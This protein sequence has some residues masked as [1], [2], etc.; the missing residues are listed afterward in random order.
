[1]RLKGISWIE[2]NFEKVFAGAFGVAA[3]GV[4]VWQFAG[5]A[6]SVTVGKKTVPIEQAFSEVVA[7]ARRAKGEIELEQPVPVLEP[8]ANPVAKF[9]QQFRGP[10]APRPEL[11]V[12]LGDPTPLPT[13]SSNPG[14]QKLAGLSELQ[15]PAPTL[16]IVQPYMITVHPDEVARDKSVA[17]VLPN[18]MPYDKASVT[19]QVS[20][21]GKALR[22]ILDT[23]PDGTGP[24]R[25]MNRLWWEGMQILGTELHRQEL[26]ADGS[27]G[28]EE[29]V[30][31]MP[32]RFTQMNEI[33]AGVSSMEKLSLLKEKAR[34][35]SVEVRR[36]TYYR[37][38]IGEKW[39]P[40]IEQRAADE[41]ARAAGPDAESRMRRA[42]SEL[43]KKIDSLNDTLSKLPPLTQPTDRND[44]PD[45]RAPSG[46]G[47]GGGSGGGGG[48][49]GASGGGGGGGGGNRPPA[50]GQPSK[51]NDQ[52]R[53]T[54]ERNR[55][56]SMK[57]ADDFRRKLGMAPLNPQP[58]D[59]S[60]PTTMPATSDA[61]KFAPTL[62]TESLQL[63]AHDVTVERG[64]SYRY[65]M[66]LVFDNPMFGKGSVMLPE[67]AE[68]A[69]ATTLR[70]EPSE[71]SDPVAT[72]KETYYFVTSAAEAGGALN[73]NRPADA[74]ADLF[75]F[76]LGYWRRGSDTFEPGDR[77]QAEVSY[78]DFSKLDIKPIDGQPGMAN[79]PDAPP[80]GGRD[81]GGGGGGGGGKGR[82]GGFA[83]PPVDNPDAAMSSSGP[84]PMLSK[85]ITA[86]AVLL[87]IER[88]ALERRNGARSAAVTET[89][90]RRADGSIEVRV[91]DNDKADETYDR[92]N[93]SSE[94]AR[95][96]TMPKKSELDPNNQGD[97]RD[98][99]PIAP[100]APGSDGGGGSG[101]GSGG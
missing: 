70:S 13:G 29:K 76:T 28:K 64:K 99:A 57:Q 68:W 24:L 61:N 49:R 89:Y 50:V 53:K 4:L 73:P 17:E 23:D 74:R 2:Q 78:P 3:L 16:P 5:P 35:R 45:D 72:D 59:A 56:E 14:D 77:L 38:L 51:E 62:D 75:I 15:I 39:L 85:L 58:S 91:P 80:G 54:L 88:A 25:S 63:W 10:V 100:P 31:S 40:P 43:E 18:A 32:G 96:A 94:S 52:R 97:R 20:F 11:V 9:D 71:W 90:L 81:G 7:E 19:V 22:K 95:L 30:R 27:W 82:I 86:D 87:G 21:D 47:G 60:D 65:R 93:R 46:G 12:A 69:R 26:L 83:N 92:L 33:D 8:R 36:P 6:N 34:E 84:I 1:M 55:D 98:S 48:K 42:L 37:E 101:G 79:P 44:K 67:Q 41:K 66:V